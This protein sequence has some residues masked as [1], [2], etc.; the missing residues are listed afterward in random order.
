MNLFASPGYEHQCWGRAIFRV[1]DVD[2]HYRAL[3]V[4]GLILEPPQ[5]GPWASV[6]FTSLIRTG[7]SFSFRRTVANTT[8]TLA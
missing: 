2:A 1:G 6:S 4:Q 7:T 3:E 5:N 8:I